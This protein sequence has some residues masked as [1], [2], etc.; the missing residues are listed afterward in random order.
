MEL[1]PAFK[2]K[3]L[4]HISNSETALTSSETKTIKTKKTVWSYER[5]DK[6]YD[7]SEYSVFYWN[8]RLSEWSCIFSNKKVQIKACWF[9]YIVN[10]ARTSTTDFLYRD[11]N[12]RIHSHKIQFTIYRW[13]WNRY[14]VDSRKSDG[15]FQ[16]RGSFSRW[17][18]NSGYIW[19][20]CR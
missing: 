3:S 14:W 10:W 7:L 20:Y 9:K 6:T 8:Q 19:K 5:C 16:V 15:W 12:P 1:I 4:I 17:L 2:I 13:E 11:T 18:V